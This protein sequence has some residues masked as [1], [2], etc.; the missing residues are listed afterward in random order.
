M[1]TFDVFEPKREPARSIYLAFQREAEHRKKRTVD[2]WLRGEREAVFDESVRQAVKMG[3]RAPSMEEVILAER[4]AA[5]HIDYGAKWAYGIVDSMMRRTPASE[6][7]Q[8]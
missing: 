5:G 6:G 8:K 4:S 7:E 2:E 3:L 1:S